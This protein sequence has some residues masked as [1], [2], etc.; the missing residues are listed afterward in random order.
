[1]VCRTKVA[2]VDGADADGG[3]DTDLV[4]WINVDLEI[5]HSS[6]NART[7]RRAACAPVATWWRVGC[8]RQAEE[9]ARSLPPL[10]LTECDQTRQRPASPWP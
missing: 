2:D 9:F 3:G 7:F 4:V 8:D 5:V 6:P 1:V 10:P